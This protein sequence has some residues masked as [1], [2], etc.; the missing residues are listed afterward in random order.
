MF[1][2]VKKFI[3][4]DLLSLGDETDDEVLEGLYE[5]SEQIMEEME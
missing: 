1:A 5:M 3:I 4:V 2:G